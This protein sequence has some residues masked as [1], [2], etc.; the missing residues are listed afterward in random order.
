MSIY[1]RFASYLT[2]FFGLW[3]FL[4]T[5]L[6]GLRFHNINKRAKKHSLRDYPLVSVIIPARNEEKNLPSLLESL[7]TQSYKNIEILIANDR[8]TDRTGEIIEEYEKKDKRIHGYS[9]SEKKYCRH[10]KMNAI[11]TL[12]PHAKGKYLLCTDADTIHSS[13]SI[14]FAMKL[15]ESNNADILSGFPREFSSSYMARTITASMLFSNV[16]IPHFIFNTLHVS[17]LAIGIGQFIMMNHEV[18]D[19]IGGYESIE[20]EICDDLA[21]IRRFMEKGKNYIF[22]NMSDVVSCNMYK[23]G[24]DAFL[25]ISR[26]LSG[27][28]KPSKRLFVA[29]ILFVLILLTVSYSPLLTPLFISSGMRDYLYM[30]LIGWC[31]LS[32]SWF[33][34]GKALKFK[35]ST[36]LSAVVSI[37]SICLMYLYSVL[38]RLRGRKFIWKGDEI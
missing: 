7:I 28:F 13:D 3:L 5:L 21:I 4:C 14:Y 15:L 38:T 34:A 23:T 1:L 32:I 35:T 33:N 31:L 29:L 19:E 27:V 18:Y 17:S 24:K 8:S 25:G 9:I 11:Q 22:T 12:I 26:S 16:C 6:N 36:S 10:G 20:N 37:T 30:T 2:L